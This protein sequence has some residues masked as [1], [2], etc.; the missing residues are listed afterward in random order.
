MLRFHC[1]RMPVLIWYPFTEAK[2][3][4]LQLPQ[5]TFT[6]SELTTETLEKYA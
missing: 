6:G 4:K 3:M 5:L 2:N 1:D